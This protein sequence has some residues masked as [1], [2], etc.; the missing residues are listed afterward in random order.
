MVKVIW[1]QAASP[2][3]MD[4][5]VV[6]ATLHQC[7]P[8]LIRAS[9]GPSESSTQVASWSAQL[10]LHKWQSIPILYNGQPFPPQNCPSSRG[11]GPPSNTI[12]WAHPSPQPKLHLDQFSHF[13][14]AHYSDRLTDRP[15]YLAYN[16]ILH[17]NGL[18]YIL[19]VRN[20]NQ[21]RWIPVYWMNTANCLASMHQHCLWH[22]QT[23][24]RSLHNRRAQLPAISIHWHLTPCWTDAMLFQS[25]AL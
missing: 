17:L 1:Q 9:L 7:A 4:G 2:P 11:S 8:H 12:L 16:N 13:C 20:S 19:Q 5:S 6:I 15:C 14:G 23:V 25:S 10:F 21:T 24:S 22:I 3:Y 18:R